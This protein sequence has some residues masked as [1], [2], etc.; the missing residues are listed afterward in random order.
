M[1]EES[2]NHRRLN[3]GGI[4]PF[5]G[6]MIFRAPPQ[7]GSVHCAPHGYEVDIEDALE[8]ARPTHARGR[9]LRMGMVGR[10]LGFV[11][12]GCR[13]DRRAQ[14]GVRGEHAVE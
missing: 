12:C 5:T 10:V 1:G 8:Q 4:V 2:R 11:L 13:N 7:F 9:K 14:L 3:D 6:T